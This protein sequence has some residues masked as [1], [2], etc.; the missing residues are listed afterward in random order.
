MDPYKI[1]KQ[2]FNFNYYYQ[3]LLQFTERNS[4]QENISAQRK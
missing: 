3:T 1:P 2:K 4:V